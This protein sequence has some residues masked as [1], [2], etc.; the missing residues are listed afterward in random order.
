M[1]KN[2]VSKE[3]RKDPLFLRNEFEKEGMYNFQIIRK[4]DVEL[5]NLELISYSDT[6]NHDVKNLH[7]AVHFFVDDWRFESI[8]SYPEK[9]FE[10]LS[11]YR[12]LLT[13][14][15][16]LYAEMPIWRQIESVGKARWVGANWQSKGLTVVPTMSWSNSMSYDFCFKA[17]EKGCVVAVGMIGCKNNK[18]WFLQGYNEMMRQVEPSAIICFGSPFEEMQG[19]IICVDYL[20]SRK[21]VR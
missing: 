4:Q 19:N 15:Y 9:S 1:K 20:N 21:V 18:S 7:K 6:S 11:K 5:S 14:D 2:K 17:V 12:F 16:S 10:K 13:P 8:Y 3:L